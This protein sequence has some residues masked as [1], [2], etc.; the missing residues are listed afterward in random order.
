M[1]AKTLVIMTG[2]TGGHI[3]PGIAVAREML[4]AGWRVVWL[5]HPDG[6]EAR[7]VPQAGIAFMPVPFSAVRGQG[8]RRL[9][10]LPIALLGAFARAY[11]ALAHLKPNV[12]LGLG[13][14]VS[15]PGGMMA[16]LRGVPL[17]LHEQNA[18]AGLANR[19]LAH[20]ADRVLTGFPDALKKGVWVG[21][22]V[23]AAIAALPAPDQRYA[24]HERDSPQRLR[25]LVLGGS[26]GAAA[27]NETVPAAMALLSPDARPEIVHQTGATDL[28]R[29]R[30]LYRL[31]GVAAHVVDFIEDMA[32]AYAW[33]D[34]VLSRAGASTLAEIAAAG[35]ASILV[36]YPH[37][38]DDHQTANARFLA[39]AGAAILLPQGE[40]SAERLCE[41]QHISRAQ[42]LEMAQQARRLAKPNAAREVALACMEIAR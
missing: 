11:R 30:D 27:I 12:A 20:V 37:A 26:Q 33:A 36:P 40:L 19:I 10:L 22:P 42:L 39:M 38:V 31:A 29:T 5:G 16:A 24:E 4:R 18:I 17:V 13:G 6:M 8:L 7:L 1:S 9:F 3:M 2:G 28:E 15:F 41:L 25:L 23:R 21:N 34:L 32:G 35:I 14:Y